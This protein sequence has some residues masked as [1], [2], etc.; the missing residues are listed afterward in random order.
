MPLRL[1]A[2]TAVLLFTWG[3]IVRL[4]LLFYG[5]PPARYQWV[6][7][8]LGTGYEWMSACVAALGVYGVALVSGRAARWGALAL[9]VALTIFN[10]VDYVYFQLFR[11]HL[12]FSALEY[13]PQL[14]SFTASIRSAVLDVR[15]ALLVLLPAVTAA[16]VFLWRLPAV[17]GDWGWKGHA[18]ALSTILVLGG[19]ANTA[20]NSF[21]GKNPENVLQ[22]TPLQHFLATRGQLQRAP[23]VLTAAA[24]TRL[25]PPDP[26]YPLLRERG[27]DGCE[28]PGAA[29]RE[30]CAAAR[31]PGA[32]G[33]ARPN[34]VFVMLESFRAQEI[35]V[36]GGGIAGAAPDAAAL[37]PN[38]DALAQ[39]GILFRNFFG[40]GFQTRHGL[41]ASNCSLFP[42]MGRPVL[43]AYDGVRERC[44]P[45]LL[46]ELG[47]R[48]VWMHNGDAEFDGQRGFLLRN[49]FERIVDRWDFP[50]GAPTA[51]WGV[52]DEALMD[53]AVAEMRALPQP[54][55]ASLLT[56]TN[57]HPFE[58][59]DGFARHGS[60]EYGRFLDTVAYTDRA[61]GRLFDKARREPFYRHTIFFLFAD[62]SVPQPPAAPVQTLRDELVWRH[63]IPLLVMADGLHGQTVDTFGSQVDL[64]PLVMDLL[65][66]RF[67]VPWQGQSPVSGSGQQPALVVSP[68][69]YVGLLAADGAARW[70]GG[71]WQT[72]GTVAPGWLPWAE[73]VTL[74]TRWALERDRVVRAP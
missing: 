67:T 72:V 42:N 58:V 11:G 18:T 25:A 16:W 73:D 15:F 29:F 43:G 2:A 66:G 23:A 36:L 53:Q 35:G 1:A 63:R 41:V 31:A 69:S 56:I 46:R 39:H 6:H 21:V 50:W 26:E 60:D 52:T 12:P 4:L 5:G 7:F 33:A 62:H 13:L 34:I 57:H 28:H 30:L 9:V 24:L 14:S 8:G 71:T 37:T 40:N 70:S 17:S 48:T 47:Y 38:F 51:G 19:L 54:F 45:E 10:Y 74:A 59:P 44:L 68:G 65:G 22:F 49:G 55:F 3:T 20:S 61:L 32:G 27:F 64:P